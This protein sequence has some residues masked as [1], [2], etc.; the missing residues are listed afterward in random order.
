MGRS[1]F[2]GI[3]YPGYPGT[4]V[5]GNPGYPG[6]GQHV[7][8]NDRNRHKLSSPIASHFLPRCRTGRYRKGFVG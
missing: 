3:R 6:T 2:P 4:R 1:G 5:P 7:P 8:P